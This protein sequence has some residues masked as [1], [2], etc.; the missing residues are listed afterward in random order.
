MLANRARVAGALMMLASALTMGWLLG[1]SEFDV[2]EDTIAIEGLDYTQPQTVHAAIALPTGDEASIFRLRTLHMRDSLAALPAVARADVRAVLPD[3]LEIAIVERVPVLVVRRPEGEFLV[4]ADGYVIDLHDP[5]APP[6]GALPAIDD[7]R[8]ELAVTLDIGRRLD[9]VETAA[10]LQLAAIT[11]AMIE[12]QA[13]ALRVSVGD[14]EGY[15]MTSTDQ[16]WRAVFGH[17]T[18]TLRPPDMIARQVQCLR[19]LIAG[20]EEDIDTVYLAPRDDG[21]GTYLPEATPTPRTSPSPS[22]SA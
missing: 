12:S 9:E 10:M 2:T 21:C 16:G 8:R 17:Y 15:V 11:P 7:E 4:D 14:D 3:R 18:P 13:E 1:S 20:S 5:A 22:P 19:L 6:A